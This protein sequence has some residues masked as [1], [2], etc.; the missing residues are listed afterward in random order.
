M[1]LWLSVVKCLIKHEVPV[2]DV[3]LDAVLDVAEL[4]VE[5]LGISHDIAIIILIRGYECDMSP[6]GNAR[7]ILGKLLFG[8]PGWTGFV[9]PLAGLALFGV[10]Y[11]LFRMAMRHY[12]STGS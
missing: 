10:M 1:L 3:G 7:H 8:W 2:V 5:L 4:L 12:R 9:T 6:L 11:T